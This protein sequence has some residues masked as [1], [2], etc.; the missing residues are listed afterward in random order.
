[1]AYHLLLFF[2][3]SFNSILYLI[4]SLNYLIS[5]SLSLFLLNYLIYSSPSSILLYSPFS[6]F[7]PYSSLSLFLHNYLISSSPSSFLPYSPFSSFFPY[8]PTY[9]IFLFNYLLIQFLFSFFLSPLSPLYLLKI[10]K[11]KEIFILQSRPNK[12]SNNK[13]FS[14]MLF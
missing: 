14:V 4:F 6:S 13:T 2:T 10:L 7:L 3:L 8:S 9:L 5:S 11:K 12:L 1:M